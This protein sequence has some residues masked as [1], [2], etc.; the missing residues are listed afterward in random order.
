MSINV[1]IYLC[2]R[3]EHFYYYNKKVVNG[4]SDKEIKILELLNK[5][6]YISQREIAAKTNISIGKV[7]SVIRFLAEQGFINIDKRLKKTNY[8]ITR[9]GLETLETFIKSSI[10][11]KIVIPQK[12]KKSIFQAVI[13][14]AGEKTDF[15]APIGL[16][17]LGDN[18]VIERTISILKNYGIRE[19]IVITG[20]QSSY[21]E[22]LKAIRGVQLIENV[23]Y[24]HTGTM[25]SLYQARDIIDDDFI[26]VEGDMVFEEIAVREV[27]I[28]ENRNCILIT[29]ESGSG[30]EV[31][32]EI[33]NGFIFKI[34]KDKHQFNKIDGEMV[35]INKIS[36]DIYHKMLDEFKN[37]ENPYFNYEYAL[38]NVA[39]TYDIGYVKIDKLIWTEIDRIWQ[40]KNLINYI[41]P[42][43]TNN[44][45]QI[46]KETKI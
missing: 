7:N 3:N 46:D 6:G 23:N 30:D 22:H 1:K 11:K 8:S 32:V 24:K 2:S 14:A 35:G 13:L 45:R 29:N 16:L 44:E 4:M 36:I 37:N 28:N 41:Y 19:I 12:K 5:D 15:D 27:L 39:R 17:S 31:L 10:D 33:R 21:Y 26:L 9:S 38:L 43:L 42:S 34:S 20:Y 25:A 40:Y 18:T